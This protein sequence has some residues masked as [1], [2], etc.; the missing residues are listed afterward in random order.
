MELRNYLVHEIT[1]DYRE[2]LKFKYIKVIGTSWLS[3][4]LLAVFHGLSVSL[5]I[6]LFLLT[7]SM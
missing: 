6:Y 3:V 5:L 4:K 2:I 7:I 1:N